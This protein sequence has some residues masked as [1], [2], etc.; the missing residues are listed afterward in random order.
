M[1]RSTFPTSALF[2]GLLAVVATA[3]ACGGSDETGGTPVDNPSIVGAGAATYTESNEAG[4]GTEASS[5][6]TGYTLDAI[7]LR[8]TG[9]F[10]GGGATVDEYRFNTGP[11]TYVE[12]RLYGDYLAPLTLNS[13]VND[14]YSTLNGYSGYLDNA[15]LSGTNKDYVVG[16]HPGAV[17][18]SNYVLEMIG[19]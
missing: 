11:F 17:P 15:W 7:G 16:I 13:Y 8:I 6:V 4:N 1:A 2:F 5:E 9:S 3:T 19:R 18:A 12:I 14:G 10:E